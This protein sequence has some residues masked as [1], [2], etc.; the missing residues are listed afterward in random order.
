V[1]NPDQKPPEKEMFSNQ[2]GSESPR[3]TWL[4]RDSSQKIW[5]AH[6]RG[7]FRF[8][9]FEEMDAWDAI[10]KVPIRVK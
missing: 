3:Q 1:E 2:S 6:P 10:Y 8:K 4:A 5:L 9:T 7:I